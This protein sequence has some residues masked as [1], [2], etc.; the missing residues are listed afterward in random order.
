[1]ISNQ[2][3]TSIRLN[4]YSARRFWAEKRSMAKRSPTREQIAEFAKKHDIPTRISK[5][6]LKINSPSTKRCDEAAASYLR[7]EAERIARRASRSRESTNTL[8]QN[9][10]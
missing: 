8:D 6:I 10:P 5:L 2:G 1:M 9:G 4:S 3:G 7:N